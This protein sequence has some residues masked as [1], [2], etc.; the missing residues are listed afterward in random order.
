MPAVVPSS[1][2]RGLFFGM[3]GEPFS[4][5]PFGGTSV[6][7]PHS[8]PA[9]LAGALHAKVLKRNTA[10]G[11]LLTVHKRSAGARCDEAPMRPTGRRQSLARRRVRRGASR[12]HA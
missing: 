3:P 4:S 8:A 11:W 1:L 10:V 6:Y 7:R 5:L 2:P 12:L 9:A